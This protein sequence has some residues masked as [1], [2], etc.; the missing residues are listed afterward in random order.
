M[1]LVV[2]GALGRAFRGSTEAAYRQ[3]ILRQQAAERERRERKEEIEDDAAELSDFA[4]AMV[5]MAEMNDF[6]IELDRYD[7][8]T[9]AA[10][11]ENEH[12]LTIARE[13]LDLIFAKAHVLPDGR[14]VFKTEDGLRVFDERGQELTAAEIDPHEIA[15]ERPRWETAKQAIDRLEAL[16]EERAAIL[17]YQEK[18]DEARERLDS[19]EMSRKEFDELRETLKTEMPE[20][21]GVQMPGI[22]HGPEVSAQAEP[23]SPAEELDI[24]ADMVPTGLRPV[25]PGYCFTC[26]IVA[27]QVSGHSRDLVQSARNAPPHTRIAKPGCKDAATRWSETFDPSRTSCVKLQGRKFLSRQSDRHRLQTGWTNLP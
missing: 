8:A 17:D 9:V 14:R 2:A 19:G 7:T 25:G 24:T 11:Q 27:Y 1:N 5:S 12:Q 4:M 20:A 3:T 21:V 23:A 10:L 26:L 15:D 13:R 6:K 18:L 22:E 16:T